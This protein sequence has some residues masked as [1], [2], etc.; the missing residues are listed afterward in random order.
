MLNITNRELN[1]NQKH[2]EISIKIAIIRKPQKTDAWH[3]CGKIRTFANCWQECKIVQLLWKTVW[4][5]L[6]RLNLELPFD[7]AIPLL[8]IHAR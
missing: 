7:P 1:E 4:P 3:R 2:N 8:G 5:F 6:K